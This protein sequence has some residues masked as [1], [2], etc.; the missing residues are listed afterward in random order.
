MRSGKHGHFL[1]AQT[2]SASSR[3]QP[4]SARHDEVA[5]GHEAHQLTRTHEHMWLE[6]RRHAAP[7]HCSDGH[8]AHT[9]AEP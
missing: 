1:L 7:I 8:Q 9:L 5:T 2:A 6:A 3:A 4:T